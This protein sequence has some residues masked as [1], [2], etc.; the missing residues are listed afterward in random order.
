MAALSI[1]MKPAGKIFRPLFQ[2][3]IFLAGDQHLPP[4][5]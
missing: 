4:Q 1:I 3:G 5:Q 2:L